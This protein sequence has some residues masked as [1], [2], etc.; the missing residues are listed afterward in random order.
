[1]REVLAR[2]TGTPHRIFRVRCSLEQPERGARRV[3]FARDPDS[4]MV[5]SLQLA[6]HFKLL[7]NCTVLRRMSFT[8]SL[9]L[10]FFRL[11]QRIDI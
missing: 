7:H 8:S 5:T 1:M 2:V 11:S 3:I 6:E 10:F 4:G 9:P